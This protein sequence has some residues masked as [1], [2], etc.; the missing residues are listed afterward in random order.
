MKPAVILLAVVLGSLSCDESASVP[1]GPLE[2][3]ADP[4]I[5]TSADTYLLDVVHQTWR[6][7]IP[8]TYSNRSPRPYFLVNCGGLYAIWLE[9]RVGESW[10]F[11][12]GPVRTLCLSPVIRIE[13]GA[14]FT[15]TLRVW[16]A[17]PGTNTVPR[18]QSEDSAG[19]YRIVIETLGEYD[20]DHYPF[21]PTIPLEQR[22]SNEFLLVTE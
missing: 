7:D 9:K 2:V 16:A 10:A 20:E 22:V 19:R 5:R 1:S 13:P 18:F 3:S 15:D 4:P 17:F 12:W 11:E 6:T 14:T 21:G 8:F